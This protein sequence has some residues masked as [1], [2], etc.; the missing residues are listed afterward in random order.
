M[1]VWFRQ[2]LRLDDNPALRAAI[3]RG[4]PVVPVFIWGPEDEGAWPAGAASKVWLDASLRSLDASLRRCGSRLII[5]RG[6]ALEALQS[7]AVEVKADAV[8][9]NRRY[10]PAAISRDAEI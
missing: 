9:W 4:G 10:E 6:R 5:R 8:L 7:L 3:G 1:I 2:D